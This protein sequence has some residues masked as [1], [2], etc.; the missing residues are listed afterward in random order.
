MAYNPLEDSDFWRSQI[1]SL[2]IDLPQKG[3]TPPELEKID[4]EV[5]DLSMDGSLTEVRV[6]IYYF[7]SPLTGKYFMVNGGQRIIDYGHM[8]LGDAI[9]S[10][11][12]R[13]RRG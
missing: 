8:S 2:K 13:K 1:N 4:S 11:T 5:H 6:N 3:L 10:I 7:S 9:K 12:R